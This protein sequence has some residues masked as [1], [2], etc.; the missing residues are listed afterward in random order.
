MGLRL[1]SLRILFLTVTRAVHD[2]SSALGKKVEFVT[3]GEDTEV[4]KFPSEGLADPLMHMTRNAVDLGQELL[5]EREQ[6]GKTRKDRLDLSARCE[7]GYLVIRLSDDGKGLDT[8]AILA[9]ARSKG[10]DVV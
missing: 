10:L 7:G 1:V 9:K 5:G 6:A 3:S 8:G 4:D 2:A